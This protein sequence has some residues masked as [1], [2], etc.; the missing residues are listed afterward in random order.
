MILFPTPKARPEHYIDGLGLTDSEYYWIKNCPNPRNVMIKKMGSNSV[1]I[2]VDLSII[3]NYLK[4]FSSKDVDRK[5]MEELISSDQP[6]WVSNFL[7]SNQY[8]I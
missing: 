6:N 4:L 1:I 5:K 8:K 2:D 7:N 3:G